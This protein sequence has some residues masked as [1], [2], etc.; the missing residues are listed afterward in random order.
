[1]NF[2][3]WFVAGIVML[4]A[5][6]LF[7]PGGPRTASSD[8]LKARMECTNRGIAYFKEVGSFPQLSDGRMAGDVAYQRCSGSD[9]AF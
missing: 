8:Q 3:G 4:I 2:V 9:K 6:A 7:W 5:V 1:M